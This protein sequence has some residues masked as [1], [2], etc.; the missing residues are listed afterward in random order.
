MLLI[1]NSHIFYTLFHIIAHIGNYSKK[2]ACIVLFVNV[3]KKASIIFD[4]R[5]AFTE[6][7]IKAIKKNKS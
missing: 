4:I 3:V 7:L 2:Q 1:F 5:L 6:G